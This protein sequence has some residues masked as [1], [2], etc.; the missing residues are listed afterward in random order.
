MTQ[1]KKR[2]QSAHELAEKIG[3]WNNNEVCHAIAERLELENEQGM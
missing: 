3:S 2:F 1:R